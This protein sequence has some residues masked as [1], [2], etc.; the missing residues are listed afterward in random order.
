MDEADKAFDDYMRTVNDHPSN[1]KM[2]IGKL[3]EYKMARK[4][5]SKSLIDAE[6]KK[7][8][9]LINERGSKSFWSYVNWKGT[10]SQTRNLS[11]PTLNE[12]ELFFEEL[13]NCDNQSELLDLMNLQTDEHVSSLEEPISE[14]EIKNAFSEIKKPGFDYNLPIMNILVASF[15]LLLV[16]LFNMMFFVKYP[17][18]LACSLLSLI[19]KSGNLKLPKNYRGIQ[20]MKSLACLYDRVIANRLKTW[21][22]F[23]V[24]QTAFQKGKSTLLHIFTLRILIEIVKKKKL[25]LYIASMDIEKAF[26]MVP[27]SLLLKKLVTL[28]LSKCA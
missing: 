15:S 1:D 27:R 18:S 13:Y 7:W 11:S 24:N 25:T 12:F 10:V 23:N 4:S 26:D 19:P 16:T 20:M 9:D 2:I 3:E 28:G 22:S 6:T 17:M 14:N 21:L 5:L 8:N